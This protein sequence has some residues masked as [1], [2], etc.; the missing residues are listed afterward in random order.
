M[1]IAPAATRRTAKTMTPHWETVGT[2][3]AGPID[4][5][6]NDASSGTGAASWN[7][8]LNFVP[9]WM[10]SAPLA[11]RSL[12]VFVPPGGIEPWLKS[13]LNETSFQQGPALQYWVSSIG[14][15]AGFTSAR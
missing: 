1:T 9:G 15:Y 6:T 14:P 12:I 7:M 8:I 13:G 4:T 5:T 10:T 2:T 3:L 11:G